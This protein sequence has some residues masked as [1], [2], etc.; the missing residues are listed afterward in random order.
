MTLDD[1]RKSL[2]ATE[3]PAGLSHAAVGLWWDARA[4]GSGRTNPHNRMKAKRDLGCT[5]TFI[6]R[7]AIRTMLRTGMIGR[8]SPFAGSRSRQSGL[9]LREV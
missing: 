7:K 3:P 8:A 4:I 1:F 5:P 2:S 9:S 6:A